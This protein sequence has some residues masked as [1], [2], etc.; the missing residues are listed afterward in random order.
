MRLSQLGLK[1]L[2]EKAMFTAK[3]NIYDL[4][5]IYATMT[6]I[7]HKNI[8]KVGNDNFHFSIIPYWTRP[9]LI[10]YARRKATTLMHFTDTANNI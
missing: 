1:E 9:S 10:R 2:D 7:F 8:A 3:S 5:N 6:N 4:R